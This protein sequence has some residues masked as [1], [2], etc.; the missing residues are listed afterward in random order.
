VAQSYSLQTTWK[1]E[2]DR[3]DRLFGCMMMKSCSRRMMMR[4]GWMKMAHLQVSSWTM[5]KLNAMDHGV[6]LP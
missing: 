5:R 4:D 1:V 2:V 6:Q 3:D